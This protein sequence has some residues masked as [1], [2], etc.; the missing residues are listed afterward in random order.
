[1]ADDLPHAFTVSRRTIGEE[2]PVP[3][4]RSQE[5]L[6][7]EAEIMAPGLQSIALFSQMAV[8]HAHGCTIVDADGAEYLDF[9]AGI[10]VG[11]LGHAHPKYT[12]RLADQLAKATFGSFTTE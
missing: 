5:I 10:C 12:Q 1:M 4:P 9:V 8:D 6:A 3:G 7:R 11:S 2:R